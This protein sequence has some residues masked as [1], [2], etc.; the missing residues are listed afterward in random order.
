MGTGGLTDIL[1]RLI[2]IATGILLVALVVVIIAQVFFRY[3]LN[4][5][6]TWSEEVAVYLMIWVVFLGSAILVRRWEHV[7]IPTLVEICPPGPRIVLIFFARIASIAFILVLIWFGT[8]AFLGSHH[9][10]SLTIGI[11]TRWIKLSIP[12]GAIIMLAYA[13]GVLID[14]IRALRAGNSERFRAVSL[15]GRAGDKHQ[16]S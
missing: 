9:A 15:V 11:S 8:E 5:S 1:D 12:V 4:S 10:N 14:D 6:L 13:V 3:V 16:E 7:Q 2:R